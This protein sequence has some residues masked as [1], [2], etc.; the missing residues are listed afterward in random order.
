MKSRDGLR[1]GA[2]SKMSQKIEK[3][4]NLKNIVLLNFIFEEMLGKFYAMCTNE[5]NLTISE[6]LKQW[7]LLKFKMKAQ[8]EVGSILRNVTIKHS[9]GSIDLAAHNSWLLNIAS[10]WGVNPYGE[11]YFLAPLPFF[12]FF[13]SSMSASSSPS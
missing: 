7:I 8:L 11:A 9:F 12:D 6:W 10:F 3:C 1:M 4:Q 13:E 5:K 2:Y